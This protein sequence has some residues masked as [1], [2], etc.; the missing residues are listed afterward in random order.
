MVRYLAWEKIKA[1]LNIQRYQRGP[2]AGILGK[3]C[4]NFVVRIAPAERKFHRSSCFLSVLFIAIY[5]EV[6]ATCVCVPVCSQSLSLIQ[7]LA[8]PWTVAHQAPLSMEISGQDYWNGLPFPPPRDLPDPGIN[9][10]LLLLL[11]W[12]VD[13]LPVHHKRPSP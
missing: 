9:L 8:A 10:H 5:S 3:W 13:S 7:F 1:L 6:L 2:Q 12:W 11:H 4:E